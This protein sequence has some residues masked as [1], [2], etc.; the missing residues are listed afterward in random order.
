MPRTHSSKPVSKYHFSAQAQS[1][2]PASIFEAVSELETHISHAKLDTEFEARFSTP[3][4]HPNAKLK[5]RISDEKLGIE[6]E[7]RVSTPPR[8]PNAELKTRV[9]RYLNG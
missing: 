7:A 3:L 9:Q 1:L 4:R 2:K 6:F 5:I 8:H